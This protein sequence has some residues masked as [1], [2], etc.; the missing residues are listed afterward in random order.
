VKTR[1]E[2][3]TLYPCARHEVRATPIR[4]HGQGEITFD[5]LIDAECW[6]SALQLPRLLRVSLR[7]TLLTRCARYSFT[8]LSQLVLSGGL[9]LNVVIK[10]LYTPPI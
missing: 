9:S 6:V 3:D 7:S 5:R 1:L 4:F 2:I 10:N 8:P